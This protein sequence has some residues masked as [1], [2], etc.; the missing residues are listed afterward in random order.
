MNSKKINLI[1]SFIALLLVIALTGTVLYAWYT[2]SRNVGSNQLQASTENDYI[3]IKKS[4]VFQNREEGKI[5]PDNQS[6]HVGGLIDGNFFYYAIE[7]ECLVPKRTGYLNIEIG[8]IN[9]GD[10]FKN[11]DGT[12]SIYNMCDIYQIGLEEVWI[13]NNQEVLSASQKEWI[14]FVHD[15]ASMVARHCRILNRYEWQAEQN[16]TITF[17][18]K[19]KMDI[20]SC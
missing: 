13:G 17:L 3:S 16:H 12:D 19:I 10:F 1:G 11:P 20:N 15:T 6:E 2:N 4:M 8:Q 18:Y 5:F 9:G 7:I 14:P